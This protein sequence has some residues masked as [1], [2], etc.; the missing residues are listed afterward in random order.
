MEDLLIAR[1]IA[2]LIRFKYKDKTYLIKHPDRYQRYVAEEIYNEALLEASV[3]GFYKDTEINDMMVDHGIWN[4]EKEERLNK[5]SKEIEKLKVSL[6][7]NF[8]KDKE[9][10]AI[11]KVIEVAKSERND[12]SS[13]KYS[14]SYLTASGYAYT[15]K[16]KY[17]I[18]SSLH[19]ENGDKVFN[20]SAFWKNRSSLLDEAVVFYNQNKM[21][22]EKIR[23][24][25]KNN[26]WRSFWSAKKSEGSIFGVPVVDLDDERRSLITWSQLYENIA[27]HMECPPDDIINDDDALD[28]WMIS[29]REESETKKNQN[30]IDSKLSDKVKNSSEIF[31]VAHSQKEK[32]M[33]ESMNSPEVQAIKR[34]R[35]KIIQEKGEVSDLDFSDVKRD[36]QMKKNSM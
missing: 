32:D 12:L 6:F 24:L 27:E 8:F 15:T 10:L 34:S 7:K 4:D 33:V 28:G 9:S 26:N 30:S 2:G 3:E 31:V 25:S 16:A 13:E 1:I 18:G 29:Q 36:I 23:Q 11:R 21:N 35:Q 5:I 22:D 17:L 14:Y 20:D 19:Y